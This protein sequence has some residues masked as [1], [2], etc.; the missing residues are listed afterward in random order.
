MQAPPD[1][2]RSAANVALRNEL[3]ERNRGFLETN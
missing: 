2:G 3:I 1:A